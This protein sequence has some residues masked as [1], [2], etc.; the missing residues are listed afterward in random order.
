[1]I[2]EVDALFLEPQ[3]S[4]LER[5]LKMPPN[6]HATIKGAPGYSNINGMVFFYQ[7]ADGVLILAQVRG[8]PQGAEP[9]SSNVFGFHI[10]E[11][12]SCTG[13][14]E[15]PFANA[16]SHYN[17]NSCLHPAH[18]GDLPPLFGNHGFAFMAFVT[19]RFSVNEVIG[20]TVII[21][22]SPDDFTT[23]PSGNSGKKIACGQIMS[24]IS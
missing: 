14:S 10:H 5:L 16:G 21:H 13:N 19:D 18:A 24:N 22:S 20:R 11:G 1:M 2:W 6:A 4:Q 12:N 8:L 15:D 23:Q 3:Y 9:C 17:P 7:A